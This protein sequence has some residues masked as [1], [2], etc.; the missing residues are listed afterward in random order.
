MPCLVE[1]YRRST[2][3]P[4]VRALLTDDAST[5]RCITEEHA[6]CWVHEGRLFKC[7]TPAIALFAEERE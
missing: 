5:I 1:G 2:D 6:L 3:G 4:V 7:L